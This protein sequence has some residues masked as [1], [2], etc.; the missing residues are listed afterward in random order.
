MYKN[1]RGDFNLF[2][3]L[4]SVQFLSRQIGAPFTIHLFSIK[5][6]KIGYKNHKKI[7]T[8]GVFSS[9]FITISMAYLALECEYNGFYFNLSIMR[10]FFF[11]FLEI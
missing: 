3:F 6:N 8:W 9:T 4:F 10:I 2:H 7:E 1:P 11:V 5:K